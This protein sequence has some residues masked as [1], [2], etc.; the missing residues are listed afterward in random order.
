MATSSFNKDNTMSKIY[1]ALT[2]LLTCSVAIHGQTHEHYEGDESKC[3]FLHPGSAA[4]AALVID[5]FE[6]QVSKWNNMESGDLHSSI[7]VCDT[8]KF[9]KKAAVISFSGDTTTGSWTMLQCKTS[10]PAGKTK[11]TFWAKANTITS[12][13][14][15]A[16]QGARHDSL[17]IFGKA[18]TI[19]TAWKKYEIGLDEITELL[20]SHLAQDG[21]SHSQHPDKRKVYAIGFSELSLPAEFIV[22]QLQWE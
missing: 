14:V 13:Y 15:T 9:G 3:P 21:H 4:N 18:I 17:E 6:S 11:I 16:Y 8:A 7:R 5:D 12:V 20:F 22:D 2:L 19:D 10:V 1:F